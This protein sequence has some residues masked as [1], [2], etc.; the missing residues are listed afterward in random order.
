M[1]GRGAKVVEFA[2]CYAIVH[3]DRVCCDRDGRMLIFKG[4]DGADKDCYWWHPKAKV[5][6]VVPTARKGRRKQR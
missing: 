4:R 5:V 2:P 1:S 6:R 3:N